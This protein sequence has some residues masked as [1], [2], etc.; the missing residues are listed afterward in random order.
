MSIKFLTIILAAL[1]LGIVVELIRRERL[2]FKYAAGWLF[3]SV[4]ALT[5]V[6]FDHVLFRIAHFFGFE[7]ASN[8]IFFTLFG[9]FV[10]LSLL[11]TVFLCQQSNRNDA[12]AKKIAM[13]E[14]EI[15]SVK[16]KNDNN[17]K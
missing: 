11:M 13:L 16:K 1:I 15:E 14:F 3:V 9:V 2:T 4:V 5:F 6:V 17:K 12:M 8:F 7:L 10:F